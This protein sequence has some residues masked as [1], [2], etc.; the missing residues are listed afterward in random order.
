MNNFIVQCGYCL[1]K[2]KILNVINEAMS[3]ETRT[4]LQYF[5][6]LSKTI[7]VASDLVDCIAMD[8]YEFEIIT[9]A[10]AMFFF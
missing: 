2:W 10:Y 7:D 3:G 5:G 1:D 6:F 9:Y 8:I 4:L